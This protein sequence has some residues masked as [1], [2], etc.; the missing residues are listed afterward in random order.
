MYPCFLIEPSH[1]VIQS[2]CAI[3]QGCVNGGYH[4]A[5]MIIR[6]DTQTSEHAQITITDEDMATVP[7]FLVCEKCGQNVSTK[8]ASRG[9]SP[10]WK[11]VDTG[12]VRDS[13]QAFGVGA[14]WCATWYKNVATGL[15]GWCWDNAT[16]APLIVRTPG[17]DWDIDSRASNCTMPQDRTH[18]CWVRHGEPPNI[19]VDKNGHTCGAGAG[20]IISGNYHGFLHNGSLTANL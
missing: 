9:A 14:M 20:S 6:V 16:E 7:E 4:R 1:E 3:V 12:E 10:R 8:G 2:V 18:R 13:I 19:H 17:G 11:R 5:E 15:Y